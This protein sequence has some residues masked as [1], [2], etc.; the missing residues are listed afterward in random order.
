MLASISSQSCI[1]WL[2]AVDYREFHARMSDLEAVANTAV[3]TVIA[4]APPSPF[5]Q[6]FLEKKIKLVLSI[7][8]SESIPR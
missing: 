8:S 1:H 2:S 5:A 4:A 3:D 6:V 7:A